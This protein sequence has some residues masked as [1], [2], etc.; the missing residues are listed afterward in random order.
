MN[1]DR[2]QLQAAATTDSE[3]DNETDNE[4][5]SVTAALQTERSAR[6]LQI[7]QTECDR[8]LSLVNDLLELQRLEAGAVQPVWASLDLREWIPEIV[9]AYRERAESRQQTLHL[10]L[11]ETLPTLV[12]DEQI[13]SS[14]LRELLTNACKYT[15]PAGAITVSVTPADVTLQLSVNNTGT[16]IPPEELP[17]LFEKFYRLV[18][19]DQWRQG[20]TGLGLS[21]VKQQV[22]RL[23]GTVSMTSDDT[24]TVFQL[25][26]PLEPPV[27]EPKPGEF[28]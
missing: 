7:L 28:L 16:A 20:G 2:R 4:T 13:F 8:E 12:T 9:L 10:E 3:T 21:L 27:A 11:P 5:E 18:S 26:L 23:G 15:P 24:A 17:R 6:Y 22:E 1:L 25:G 14:V 19:R